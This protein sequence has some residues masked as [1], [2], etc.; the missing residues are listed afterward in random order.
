MNK[1]GIIWIG[2]AAKVCPIQLLLISRRW[3][4]GSQSPK[5]LRAPAIGVAQ[6]GWHKLDRTHRN[7]VSHQ[8][9]AH[10]VLMVL[11][12]K[13]NR[14]SDGEL[15]HHQDGAPARRLQPG[16]HHNVGAVLLAACCCA[17]VALKH[18]LV[19]KN[20]VADFTIVFYFAGHPIEFHPVHFNDHLLENV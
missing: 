20:S 5:R 19:K 2:N 12:L 16:H 15:G 3:Y 4:P 1:V 11:R 7:G 6:R 13:S 18:E 14:R 10:L 8:V 17:F 9:V